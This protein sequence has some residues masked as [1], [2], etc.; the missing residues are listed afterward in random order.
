M[1][2]LDKK[3]AHRLEEVRLQ[4]FGVISELVDDFVR[5][6][7]GDKPQLVQYALCLEFIEAIAT[8]SVVNKIDLSDVLK[9]LSTCYNK[10]MNEFAKEKGET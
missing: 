2:T 5:D 4:A 6:H 10:Y 9:I 3:Y 8:Y 1:T 7:W